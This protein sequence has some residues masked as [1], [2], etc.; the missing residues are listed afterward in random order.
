MQRA[1]GVGRVG[2]GQ[3]K[4]P[5]SQC[6]RVCQNYSLAICPLVFFFHRKTQEGCGGLRGENPAVFPKAR[7]IF[8]QPYSLPENAQTLAGPAFRAAGKSAKNFPAASKFAGKLFEQ[9]ISDSHSLLEF[10]DFPRCQTI[11][12]NGGSTC[13]RPLHSFLVQVCLLI[14]VWKQKGF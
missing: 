8:Q 11:E 10:S 9:G 4:E 5:A 1:R 7:P 14:N 3:A 13:S 2:S 12:M 6:A